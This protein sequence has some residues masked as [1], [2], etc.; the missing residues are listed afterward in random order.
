MAKNKF[1]FEE[2]GLFFKQNELGSFVAYHENGNKYIEYFNA[3]INEEYN[4]YLPILCTQLI[5]N[6]E[7]KI[8]IYDDS[9]KELKEVTIFLTPNKGDSMIIFKT[10]IE[11]YTNFHE[12]NFT[13]SKYLIDHIEDNEYND[14]I[15]NL[16]NSNKFDLKKYPPVIIS[17]PSQS[18]LRT[19]ANFIPDKKFVLIFRWSEISEEIID[20]VLA[21][22][23]EQRKII[24]AY[25]EIWKS[26]KNVDENGNHL[27]DKIMDFPGSKTMQVY[28]REWVYGQDWDK[29]KDYDYLR[30]YEEEV[31]NSLKITEGGFDMDLDDYMYDDEVCYV[32]PSLILDVKKYKTKL[33]FI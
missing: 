24:M 8:S 6:K 25:D 11:N 18:V 10:K 15:I 9:G 27:D 26:A 22:P 30:L 21:L 4:Y 2:N 3:K 1:T 12:G 20:L 33:K 29:Y 23:K 28:K 31:F 32:E 16:T 5:V 13:D 7:T 17:I 14:H 19:I